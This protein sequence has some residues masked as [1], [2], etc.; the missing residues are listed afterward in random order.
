MK[1]MLFSICA[2]TSS[3]L[4]AQSAGNSVQATSTG[5]AIYSLGNS[6]YADSYGNGFVPYTQ[7]RG[8]NLTPNSSSAASTPIKADVMINMRANS[9]VALLSVTQVG[10]SIEET[11]SLMDIRLNQVFEALNKVGI[12]IASTHVD[13]IS[14]VPKYDFE[15]TEKKYSKTFNEVPAGFEM[16]KNIHV[17]FE[18]HDRIN[19]L[20]SAAAKAEIYDLV[21]ID[22]NIADMDVVYEQLRKRAEEII[23][24]KTE[25]YTRM[26]FT[27]E[28]QHYA[29][30]QGSVYAME[31]YMKYTAAHTTSPKFKAEKPG[32]E[33][34]VDINYSEKPSTIYYE[35]VPYSQFD[36]VLNPDM[37]EPGVQFYLNMTVNYKIVLADEAKQAKEDRDLDLQLRRAEIQQ[38]IKNAGGQVNNNTTVT[39]R[40][41]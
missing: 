35:K 23:A 14:M 12:S 19:D 17:K 9:Y 3:L 22:Y 41:R 21:K 16:K 30:T 31:R 38:K 32:K 40:T 26:G 1:T 15:S 28:A 37:A 20:I 25:S 27:L 29:S 34:T 8:V 36:V 18:E 24:R 13:F 33:K 5:N 6:N 4:C 10:E 7:P 2:L 11:D 39:V